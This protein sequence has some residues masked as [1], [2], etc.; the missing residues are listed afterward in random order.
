[1]W[2]ALSLLLVG[3]TMA[4][5]QDDAVPPELKTL[6]A[7]YDQGKLANDEA[8]RKKYIIELMNLRFK[9]VK[10]GKDTWQAVDSEMIR[11]PG[12][13]PG[14][15]QWTKFLPGTWYSSRHD[16]L[17][18][19]DG[20]W[21]MLPADPDATQ[22]TWVI[23]GNQLTEEVPGMDAAGNK[24]PETIILINDHLFIT[25]SDNR[26]FYEKRP[27]EGGPPLRRDE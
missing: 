3:A 2:R 10:E 24:P 6:E 27:L 21:T 7:R 11:H 4:W 5:A 15:P 14:D 13:A 19:K 1:M 26:V 20:T 16:Y 22:G 23:H 25:T 12:P 8:L 18:K 17:Y 9:L